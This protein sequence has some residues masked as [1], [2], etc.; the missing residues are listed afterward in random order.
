MK[1]TAV[2]AGV[3]ATLLGAAAM[4]QTAQQDQQRDV[5][6]QERIEQG[7]KSGELS[8]REAG[9]LERQQ[10]HIDKM[11][12]H[13]LKNGSISPAEQ[14]RLNAAQNKASRSI[15]ADKHNGVTGNPNSASSERMQADVQRNVDQQQRIANGMKSGALTNREAGSLERGQAHVDR[16]EANAAAN[17]HVSAAEQRNIQ[18]SENHQSNRIYRK[19]HNLRTK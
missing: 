14:A 18:A 6:Q 5:N 11:E 7:L 17:G 3:I 13:D 16:K 2:Y 19:K 4:A 8:T 12:A 1:S 9:Q 10:Q 15:Y